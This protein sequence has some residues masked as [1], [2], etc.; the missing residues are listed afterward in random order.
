MSPLISKEDLLQ[1]LSP[2]ASPFKEPR[3]FD[4]PQLL[5]YVDEEHSLEAV[6]HFLTG[7]D[8]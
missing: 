3:Y 4:P 8:R 6:N 5:S 7:E 1:S 2:C